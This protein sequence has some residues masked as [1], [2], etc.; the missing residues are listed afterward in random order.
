MIQANGG[1]PEVWGKVTY[2]AGANGHP[3]LIHA[4]IVGMS[5]RGWPRESIK[6]I[7]ASGLT[8]EDVVAA[9]DA[10]RRHLIAALPEGTRK[11][12]YRLSLII[13]RFDRPLA[14]ALGVLP[15]PLSEPGEH[16]DQLI[17][18][19]VEFVSKTYFRVSPLVAAAGREVLGSDERQS[20]HNA[21]AMR[22]LAERTI[23]VADV[24]VVFSHALLGK[25]EFV[26]FGLAM[27]VLSTTRQIRESLQEWFFLLRS[28]RTK[29]IN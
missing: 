16:F 24:N 9:R 18:S 15:P 3:Q 26:L 13:G 8:T 14:L 27:G 5:V 17:G 22:T 19:W 23:N 29:R 20:I 11:L 4:F 28:A 10:A 12:L 6:E 2:L 1:D 7:V 21:I 25:S